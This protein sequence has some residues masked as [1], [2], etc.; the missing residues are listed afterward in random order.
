M[1]IP[2]SLK[3]GAFDWKIKQDK[4][5]SMEGNIYG[6]T[7]HSTQTLFFDPSMTQQKAEECL[8]HESLHAIWWQTGLSKRHDQKIEEE[9]VHALAHGIYQVLKDNK[10]LK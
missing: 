9:I 6:S 5:V 2:K 3:I 1:K 10:L 8:I 7:H 4:D